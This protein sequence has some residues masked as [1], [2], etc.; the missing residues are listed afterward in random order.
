MKAVLLESIG[1]FIEAFNE[2]STCHDHIKALFKPIQQGLEY[3]FHQSWAQV[4]HL[5][6]TV[7]D[8]C[9]G[10]FV[11]LFGTCL[12]ALADLR[13]SSHFSYINELDYVIGKAVR[14]LGPQQVL[15]QIPLDL[16]NEEF[17]RSWIFPV[18]R[19]NIRQVMYNFN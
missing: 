17:S 18:L 13:G 16:K 11:D 12:Q 2:D 7:L 6:A 5:L 10:H 3:A 15:E 4:L 1:P 8:I 14:T 9:Q 19:E